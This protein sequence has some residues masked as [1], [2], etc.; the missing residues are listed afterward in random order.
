MIP[1]IE[2]DSQGNIK[3]LY[4]DEVDLYELGLVHSVRRASNVEFNQ[5]DQM[6]E[7][8]NISSNEIVYRHKSRE[9]AIDWEITN[10]SPG[11]MYYDS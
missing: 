8:I 4:T 10:F 11:G 6:W 9:Q 5:A 7:V 2:I 1:V 3:T